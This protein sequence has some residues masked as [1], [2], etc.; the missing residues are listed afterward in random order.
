MENL[1]IKHLSYHLRRIKEYSQ[2]YFYKSIFYP[3]SKKEILWD[4]FTETNHFLSNLNIDYWAN[5]G[6]LLGFH[7]EQDIMPH[8]TDIDFG[9]DDQFFEQIWNNK[10][11]LSSGFKMFDST[12]RHLGPKLYVSYKGFDADI[13]F[14]KNERDNLHTYEKTDWENY[15]RPIP[16]KLVYPLQEI[17]VKRVKTMVP[18]NTKEYLEFIYGSLSADAQRNPKTGFWE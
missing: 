6:T 3:S 12:S 4:L 9:C 16:T 13:Y 2:R 11:N 14:Y 10:K 17:N 1:L 7:R 18:K 8:D 15:T 5:F